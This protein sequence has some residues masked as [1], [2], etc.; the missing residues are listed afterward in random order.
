MSRGPQQERS[1]ATHQ[2]L[3]EATVECLAETGWSATTLAA[4]AAR[5]GVSRGAMQHHFRTREDLI[6]AAL[7]LMFEQRMAE[8]RERAA[9]IPH[10]HDHVE[11][12]LVQLV[13]YF[14]GVFFK[15][16]L[17]VWTA[18]AA[19]PALRARIL[20]LEAKFGRVVHRTAID[21]LQADDEDPVTHRLVQATL[22]MARG[23]GLANVLTDDSRRRGQVVAVWAAH[24]KAMLE[25]R[26]AVAY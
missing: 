5:A 17:Q 18:A 6:T 12:I 22:D 25:Q 1:R 9:A 15:A 20:P 2:R 3:L 10:G 21:L 19:D 11:T 13:D 26:R 24:L 23:L 8:V 14:T 7:D 16:A 4:V